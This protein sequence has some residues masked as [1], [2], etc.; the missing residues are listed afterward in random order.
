VFVCAGACVYVHG[1]GGAR[2][3]GRVRVRENAL[4]QHETR[5]RHILSFVASV[6]P[7]YFSTMSH[8]GHYFWENVTEHK[9]CFDFLYKLYLKYFSF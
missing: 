2:A 1:V 9:M 6:A 8:K 4:I 3:R 7:P 5:F